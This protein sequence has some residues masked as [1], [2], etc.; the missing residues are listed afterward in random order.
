MYSFYF[1]SVMGMS[2]FGSLDRR[3]AGAANSGNN[4][5]APAANN[6]DEVETGV[7]ALLPSQTYPEHSLGHSLVRTQSLGSVEASRPRNLQAEKDAARGE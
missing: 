5:T 4:I 7:P 1:R 2:R 3:R 6:I